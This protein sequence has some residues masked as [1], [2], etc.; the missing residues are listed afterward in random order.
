MNQRKEE[1]SEMIKKMK[2]IERLK[3]AFKKAALT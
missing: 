3:R 1:F 2:A